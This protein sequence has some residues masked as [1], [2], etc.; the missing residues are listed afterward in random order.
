[1]GGAADWISVLFAA[2]IP[3]LLGQTVKALGRHGI[4][5]AGSKASS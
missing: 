5:L 1:V 4:S 2:A 3:L